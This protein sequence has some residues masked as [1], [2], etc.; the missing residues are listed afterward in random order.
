MRINKWIPDQ[1]MFYRIEMNIIKMTIKVIL[2]ADHVIPETILPNLTGTM[3]KAIPY[4][5]S[6]LKIMNQF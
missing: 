3:A 4:R 1:A 6:Y 5:I 2:I